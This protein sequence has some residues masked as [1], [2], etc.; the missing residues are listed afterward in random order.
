LDEIAEL[1][2]GNQSKLL[3]LIEHGE[4]HTV[5]APVP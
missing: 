1:S 3:R 5:G 4:I 2:S